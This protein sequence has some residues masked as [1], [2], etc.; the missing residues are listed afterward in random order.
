MKGSQGLISLIIFVFLVTLSGCA[1]TTAVSTDEESNKTLTM[2][3]PWS[4]PGLDP[5][6][7]GGNSWNVMRSGAGETLIRLDEQLESTP[8]LAKEWRQEDETSWVFELEENVSFHNGN[9]MDATSVKDSLLRSVKMSQRADDLLQIESIEV[10]SDYELNIITRQPNS[11]LIS[12]LADPSSIILDVTTIEEESSFPALTGAFKF[13]EFKKDES[14]TVERFDEYW[15]EK[16][17]LSEVTLKFVADGNTRLM[18][19]QSGEVDIAIDIPIDSISL[20]ENKDDIQVVTAPSMRTHLV[21]YNMN[22]PL[23]KELNH[24]KVVDT[25]IPR[26]DIVNSVM[27]GYGTEATTPF[28]DILP[29]GK[30]ERIKQTQ[31]VGELMI[32]SGWQKNENDIWEKE[33]KVFE[34]KML[35]FPQRPELSVMAEIIQNELGKKG[36]NVSIRQV[37]SIDDALAQDDWDLSMYS[38]LTAHTG[39]PRYF[40]NIFYRENSTSNF[41]QYKSASLE[42]LIDKLNQTTETTK[43][44]DLAIQAQEIIMTDI[45]QSFI[46]HPET[47]FGIKKEVQGFTAHPIEYYY[48]HPKVSIK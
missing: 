42:S 28:T 41:S 37:E 11:A 19:L 3:F 23:F 31:S 35:T 4:P 2:A 34:V 9:E 30:V 39:D 8:W 21:L 38:M 14:L 44:N 43:R 10:I 32:E 6:E 15:G 47:A 12:H 17:L 48:I 26:E 29:F 22:S 33:G 36:I 13:K 7:A 25:S 5:H 1:A 16:A 40:L 20:L 46:V 18:S 27:R 24:R 45:P